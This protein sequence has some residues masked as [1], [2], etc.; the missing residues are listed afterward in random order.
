VGAVLLLFETILPGIVAGLA[1]LACLVSGVAL[2]YSRFGPGTGSFVLLG[3][4]LFLGIG[5]VLWIRYF[6]R[7]PLARRFMARRTI[8]NIDAGKPELLHQTGV[9]Q[10]PLRPSGVAII[11]QR[12]VDVITE[13][14]MI[15]PGT[16]VKVVAV[17]GM[18][19]VVRAV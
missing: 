19:V 5:A 15:E 6:P 18:R 4:F 16:A 7:T 17:E 2:A 1:G 8:G 9:A 11:G 14:S 3:V 13:G 12:R 10:S